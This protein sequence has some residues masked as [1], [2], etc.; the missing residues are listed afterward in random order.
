MSQLGYHKA[1]LTKA[2]N[3]LRK[4]IA[5]VNPTIM[6]RV[7]LTGNP[8]TDMEAILDRKQCLIVSASIIDHAVSFLKNQWVAAQEFA[9]GSPDEHGEFPLLDAI[10]AHWDAGEL[11][12]AMEEA[13]TLLIRL[14]A[15][16]KLLPTPEAI[17][18]SP[19]CLSAASFNV[20]HNSPSPGQNSMGNNTNSP[21]RSAQ[22]SSVLVDHPPPVH[23]SDLP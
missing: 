22:N 17:A 23:A 5:D 12:E 4:K 11:D 1:Q 21:H 16:T 9:R 8:G 3:A 2:G 6:E 20:A 13:D 7:F 14:D 19:V 10:Q 15:A 18:K